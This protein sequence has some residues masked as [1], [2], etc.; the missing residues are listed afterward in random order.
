MHEG[1]AEVLFYAWLA[2]DMYP[3]STEVRF[4]CLQAQ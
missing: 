2:S 1:E 3:L 4:A